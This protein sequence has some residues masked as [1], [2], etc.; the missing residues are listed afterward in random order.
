MYIANAGEAVDFIYARYSPLAGVTIDS[1][2]VRPGSIFFGLPGARVDGGTFAESALKAGANL[3]VVGREHD[4][5][6]SGILTVDNP[7]EVLR[8]LAVRRREDIHVPLLAITGTNGKTTTTRLIVRALMARYR[9]AATLGNFNNA[10]GL[11]L[12]LL[13]VRDDD[14]IVVLE[15]GANHPGEIAALCELARPT[16]G[17]ITS[18]GVAH[19][20]G[21]GSIEGVQQTKGELFAYLKKHGGTAFVRT[22]DAR[23]NALSELYHIGCSAVGYSLAQYHVEVDRGSIPLTMSLEYLGQRGRVATELVGGYNAINVVAAVHV[24]TFFNVDFAKALDALQGFCPPDARSRCEP[25][26]GRLVIADCYN[27]NPSSM[28]VALKNLASLREEGRVCSAILGSMLELGTE[29]RACHAEVLN[30]VKGMG[31]HGVFLVGKEWEGLEGV[32]NFSLYPDVEALQR[33]LTPDTFPAGGVIL[34]KGSHGVHL[35]RLLPWLGDGVE[36]ERV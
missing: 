1:R 10:L 8:Q 31:L 33:E 25:R 26:G 6:P 7:L 4:G 14:E 20:E 19:L 15:M 11:P 9:V 24:A 29:S 3:A 12:S 21:F 18:I 23:V 5:L 28:R 13:R 35:E 36:A 2:D 16:H 17:L 32:A 30:Q 22:D 34:L 27:A